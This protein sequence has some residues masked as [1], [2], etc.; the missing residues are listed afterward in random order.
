M[1]AG[2]E[3]EGDVLQLR[4]G[5]RLVEQLGAQMYPSATATVAEL[6][7]NAWDADARHVW[8]QMP[9]GDW[10]HGEILVVDD[11]VGMSRDEAR[12]AYLVVGR[13]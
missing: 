5:G 10:S 4:F 8:V 2:A 1:D 7:S 12:D 9:F 6:I 11:G 13:N 3:G